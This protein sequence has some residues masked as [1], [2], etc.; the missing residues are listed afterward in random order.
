MTTRT[1]S[2]TLGGLD[3]TVEYEVSGQHIH[4]VTQADP[5]YCHPEEWPELELRRLTTP[6]GED[7][8]GLLGFT[9]VYEELLE[10]VDEQ[11]R[12]TNYGCDPDPDDAY[13]RWR[14]DQLELA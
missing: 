11:E 5:E 2:I 3:L 8:S 9:P 14:D 1:A 4:A 6:G 12:E 10:Q 13:D 7:V